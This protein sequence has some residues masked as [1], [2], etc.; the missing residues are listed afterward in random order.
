[1]SLSK[2]IPVSISR[3]TLAILITEKRRMTN[4][5]FSNA[6]NFNQS[7]DSSKIVSTFGLYLSSAETASVISFF[8][9][10]G[11]VGFLENFIL[12]LSILLTDQFADTPSN[13]FILS[14][15][16]ADLL[17][18]GLSAPLFVYNCYHPIFA[19]FATVSKFNAVASTGSIF[20]LSLDRYISLVR[21]LQYQ[22]VMTFKRTVSLVAGLQ[23]AL[24]LYLLRLIYTSHAI[25]LV[26]TYQ[27]PL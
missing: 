26:S 17:V 24:L 8:V 6:S 25:F 14:L 15:A 27:R 4:M 13:I 10:F 19:I 23:P 7:F 16:C 12:I 18:C 22:K 21:G 5:S 3:R 11:T 1:M 20:T 2:Y 9:L